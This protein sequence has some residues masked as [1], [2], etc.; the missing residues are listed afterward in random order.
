MKTPG[1]DHPIHIAPNPRR[2][3]VRAGGRVLA[4]TRCALTLTEAAYPPVQY[5]PRADVD[6]TRLVKSEHATAC[7]FKGGATYYSIESERGRAENAAWS[8]ETPHDAVAAIAGHLA[9]YPGRIDSL[10]E[11]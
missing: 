6:M 4:D 3:V 11:H 8:Y 10:E 5:V 2:V 1:P 9:F 7:P